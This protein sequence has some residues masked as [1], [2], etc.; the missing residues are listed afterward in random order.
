MVFPVVCAEYVRRFDDVV[1]E[2]QVTFKSQGYMSSPGTSPRDLG[3]SRIYPG[4]AG[5]RV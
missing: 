4:A 2:I 1:T 3:R 5:E